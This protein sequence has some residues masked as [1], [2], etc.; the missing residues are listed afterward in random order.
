M[1][2][3]DIRRRERDELLRRAHHLLEA[4]D[5]VEAAWLFGSLGRGTADGLSDLDLFV[6]VRDEGVAQ[7]DALARAHVD[8]LGTPLLLLDAPQNAPSQGI[9]FMALY[10]GEAGPHQVDWYWQPRSAARLPT[11]TRLLFE[12]TPLPRQDTPTLFAYQS[13]PEW[14]PLKG[15]EEAVN[16]FWVMLLITAKY[17]ARSPHERGMG[18]FTYATDTLR[19]VEEFVGEST[20]LDL[21]RVDEVV[22]PVEKIA[23]LRRLAEQMTRK[24]PRLAE[25]GGKVPTGIVSS[26]H[27]YLEFIE[28]LATIPPLASVSEPP[29]EG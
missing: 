5:R 21:D 20:P 26:A 29:T 11:E 28:R 25:M 8:G 24:L 1:E 17:I 2:R 22:D 19:S 3:L 9:Y 7:I 27:R 15:A 13:V 16:F 4:D 12:R 14:P 10:E 6:V 18:L 23:H